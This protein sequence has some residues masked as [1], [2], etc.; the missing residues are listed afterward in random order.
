MYTTKRPILFKCPTFLLP[1]FFSVSFFLSSVPF[2]FLDVH[3]KKVIILPVLP[4][5]LC[6]SVFLPYLPSLFPTTF[7]SSIHHSSS[8]PLFSFLPSSLFPTSLHSFLTLDHLSLLSLCFHFFL[9]SFSQSFF[10]S[11]FHLFSP[12][13]LSSCT[14]KKRV[15]QKR[16]NEEE[17]GRNQKGGGK[18]S[19]GT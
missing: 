18:M 6:L 13:F 17:E 16:S 3:D 9:T 8:F 5:S 1:S 19:S 14:E 12:R 10:P 2:S 7:I 4:C 11:S 15:V